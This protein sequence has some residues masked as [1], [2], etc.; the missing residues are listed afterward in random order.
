[1][2]LSPAWRAEMTV[3]IRPAVA[4]VPGYRPGRAAPPAV[5][6]PG[7]TYKLSSNENPYPPLP[8]VLAAVTTACG[9]D[10]PL[11][12]HGQPAPAR[13]RSARSSGSSRIGWPSGPGRWGCSTTC[14]RRSASPATRWST[15]G[16]ASRRTR[17]RSDHRRDPGAGAA[18]RGCRARSGGDAGR[19]HPGDP[20]GPALHAEQPDRTGAAARRGRG[21]DR[22]RARRRGG[23][24][25]RGVRGVRHRRPAPS[26]GSISR[27]EHERGGAAD[28]L[29]GVRAGR[30]P[31]RVTAWPRPSWP[32]PC[33]PSRCR[34]GSR[35]RPRPPCS[36]RW[37]PS[38]RCWDRVRAIIRDRDALAA[39]L[40]D[41]G[42]AVPD[43]Q[44]NFVWLPAR[45]TDRGVRRRLRRGG[46]DRPAVR[47]RRPSRRGPDHRRR[48]RG[49]RPGARRSPPRS[50]GSRLAGRHRGPRN[51]TC[52]RLSVCPSSVFGMAKSAARPSHTCTECGWTTRPLGRPLR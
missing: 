4:G 38:P 40:R 41:L 28:V 51:R 18:R 11:S 26:A 1:M 24:D 42:F 3:R 5:D 45:T 9:A 16:G 44:A 23:R 27:I 7:P 35:S 39:G 20:G 32:P 10:E 47:R 19:G 14:C 13:T 31:G 37:P 25:R 43:S 34:S 17:S 8:A 12:R 15:P 2:G 36:R 29:Q 49:Q 6:A 48:A 21:D 52:R 50:R 30:L 46:A 33:G 22:R